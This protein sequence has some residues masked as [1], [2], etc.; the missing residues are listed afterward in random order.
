MMQGMKNEKETDHYKEFN[1]L[2]TETCQIGTMPHRNF[3]LRG[4]H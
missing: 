3:D 1:K 4:E 2:C